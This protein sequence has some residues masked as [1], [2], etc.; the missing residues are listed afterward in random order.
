[1]RNKAMIRRLSTLLVAPVLVITACSGAPPLRVTH[2]NGKV[3][4]DLR[5]LGEYQTTVS[6]LRLADAGND[7]VVWEL[8]VRSGEPQIDEIV[9]TPGANSSMLRGVQAGAYEVVVPKNSETFV[10]ERSRMYTV[11]VWGKTGRSARGTFSL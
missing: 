8:R 1:M 7:A 5:T 11:E 4:V 2:D 6:R 9:L 10:L 3:V